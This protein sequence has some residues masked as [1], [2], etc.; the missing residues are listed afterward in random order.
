MSNRRSRTNGNGHNLDPAVET[1]GI[2]RGVKPRALAEIY[3]RAVDRGA[4][5]SMTGSNHV[6]INLPSGQSAI[7]PL[8]SGDQM[9]VRIVTTALRRKGLD[10][11]KED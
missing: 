9:S 3:R 8:T 4:T 7:G 2:L 5:L 6:R 11:K 1:R 10:L